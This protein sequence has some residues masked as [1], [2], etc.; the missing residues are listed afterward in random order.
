[1]QAS[2]ETDWVFW[3]CR[4]RK[5]RSEKYMSGRI[6]PAL[7]DEGKDVT[8][9]LR[10][11]IHSQQESRRDRAR[12]RH[13]AILNGHQTSPCNNAEAETHPPLLVSTLVCF[14]EQF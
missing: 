8:L 4:Q 13:S 1:M 9:V 14:R 2:G 6:N 3:R 7:S 12:L 5:E 10:H 11:G